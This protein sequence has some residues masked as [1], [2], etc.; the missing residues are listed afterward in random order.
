MST[1]S[2][3]ALGAE[4]LPADEARSADTA[5]APDTAGLNSWL[6]LDAGAFRHNLRFLRSL[7][8]PAVELSSV[9]KSNAYGHGLGAIARLAVGAGAD[10]FCVHALEE[11]QALRRLGFREDVLIMGHV[12]WSRLEEAVTEDFRIVLFDEQSARRLAE[13]ARRT[14]R[15]PRVHLKIE[16]GT[17]RQGLSGEALGRLLDLLAPSTGI[18]VEGAYTHF[19]DIED[20]TDHRYARRQLVRF[21]EALAEL[22]R[23]G[24]RIRRRHAACSAAALLFP[25]THFDMVRVGISQYGFWSSKETRLSFEHH[26]GGGEGPRPVLT[27]KA[28]ISQVKDIPTDASVGYG[29]TWRATRPTRLA[30]LPIGYADGYDRGLSNAAW[31]LVR[32]RRAPVR[33]RICMNL[34]MIDV[35]DIP[36]VGVEDEVVLLGRSGEEEV[37]AETLAALAGTLHYEIVTR[38]APHLPRIVLD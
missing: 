3:T 23:R 30:I 31:V 2:P 22:T 33:G 7:V 19:A 28:R 17:H 8:G 12:P 9:V 29:R 11:A 1:A 14:G 32:G 13:I 4:D 37:S 18:E 21:E 27:W 38:I 35:T 15:R 26:K 10:S 34:T 20:T 25:E 6:E 36:G 16:T 24:Q 5:G